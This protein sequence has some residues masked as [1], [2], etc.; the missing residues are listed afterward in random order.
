MLYQRAVEMI[1]CFSQDYRIT[2][3]TQRAPLG[4]FDRVFV[5]HNAQV[6]AGGI[7]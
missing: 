1:C 4:I 5:C 3:A 2:E 7:Q 6:P